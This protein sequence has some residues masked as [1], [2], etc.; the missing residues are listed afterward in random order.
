MK[1]CIVGAGAI[2]G[3][4]GTRL[5]LQGH[6]VSAYARGAT[7][8]ALRREGWR[9][10]QG[11]KLLQAAASAT[12]EARQLGPQDVLLIA[13]KAPALPPLAAALQA[14]DRARHDHRHGDE[15]RAVVVLR[16]ARRRGRRCASRSVDPGGRM[17]DLLPAGRCSA[18]SCTRPVRRPSPAWCSTASATD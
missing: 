2:G 13:L 12:D 3:W 9:L 8:A 15:R 7:L 1:I 17:R 18:A 10:R 6:A 5:A 16:R 4:L 11:G 14:A